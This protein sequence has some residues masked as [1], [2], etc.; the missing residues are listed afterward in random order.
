MCRVTQRTQPAQCGWGRSSAARFRAARPRGRACSAFSQSGSLSLPP[1]PPAPLPPFPPASLPPCLPAKSPSPR[2]ASPDCRTARRPCR[3][4]GTQTGGRRRPGVSPHVRFPAPRWTPE[5]LCVAANRYARTSTVADTRPPPHPL[6]DTR[7]KD[8]SSHPRFSAPRRTP[9]LLCVAGH[10]PSP[11]DP[12]LGWV[13]RATQ[14]EERESPLSSTSTDPLPVVRGRART[15]SRWTL[16]RRSRA[17]TRTASQ[18]SRP[19]PLYHR[20]D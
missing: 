10:E 13:L 17:S 20:D 1:C 16:G 12:A 9:E 11:G 15:E 6:T 19:N 3:T 14:R 2:G 18:S 7:G 4:S 8:V 5:L